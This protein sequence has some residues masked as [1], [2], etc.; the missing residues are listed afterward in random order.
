MQVEEF[1]FSPRAAVVKRER[2]IVWWGRLICYNSHR[3]NLYV[4]IPQS[5]LSFFFSATAAKSTSIN[6]TFNSSRQAKYSTLLYSSLPPNLS[7]SQTSSSLHPHPHHPPKTPKRNP[8]PST[9]KIS[10]HHQLTLFKRSSIGAPS[11]CGEN[12]GITTARKNQA[13]QSK[14]S[15][16][17]TCAY[18][19]TLRTT[20]MH[21]MND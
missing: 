15:K 10:F 17:Q 6:H 14:M 11:A 3:D 12:A 21:C 5:V 19:C 18:G 4:L 13:M 16:A 9:T 8:L 2:E 20:V 1:S 7:S